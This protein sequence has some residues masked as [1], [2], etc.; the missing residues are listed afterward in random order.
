MSVE[1]DDLRLDEFDD[2]VLDD[3]DDSRDWIPTFCSDQ[4]SDIEDRN[5]IF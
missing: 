4:I 1:V 2:D 5:S 3:N